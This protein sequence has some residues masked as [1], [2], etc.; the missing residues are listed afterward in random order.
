MCWRQRR[1]V[2]MVMTVCARNDS[3]IPCSEERLCLII[4][5]TTWRWKYRGSPC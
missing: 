5:Q 2:V 1:E 4:H 3:L